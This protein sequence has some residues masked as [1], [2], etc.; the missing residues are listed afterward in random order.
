MLHGAPSTQFERS[1]LEEGIP[2]LVDGLAGMGIPISE[3]DVFMPAPA[4][5]LRAICAYR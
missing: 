4:V 1:A 3:D 5:L 2:D